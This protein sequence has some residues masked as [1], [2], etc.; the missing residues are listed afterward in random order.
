MK[1][2]E[3]PMEFVEKNLTIGSDSC[4]CLVC[5]EQIPR[6]KITYKRISKHFIDK[7]AELIIS[8]VL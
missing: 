1:N 7:H 4:L 3:L 5:M 2:I 6:S 8:E